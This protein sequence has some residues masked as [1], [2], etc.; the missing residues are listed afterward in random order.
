MPRRER[1]LHD[2]L[3]EGIASINVYAVLRNILGHLALASI[4]SLFQAFRIR[5]APLPF[6]M[7]VMLHLLRGVTQVNHFNVQLVPGCT[8]FC[9]GGGSIRNTLVHHHQN[10]KRQAHGPV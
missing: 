1:G 9:L 8:S 3:E 10:V 4:G 5:N 2:I 6:P 7:A